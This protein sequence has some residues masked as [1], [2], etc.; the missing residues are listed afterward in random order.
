[1]IK[2]KKNIFA[3]AFLAV[4][5]LFGQSAYA[6]LVN[7]STLNFSPIANFSISS[8]LPAD[9]L[10]S[11]FAMEV[12][13]G[14]F[15]ITPLTSFNGLVLGTT[16]LASSAPVV[17]NIDNP[18]QFFGNIGASQTISDANVL[19][20]SG[21]TATVDF[22][23]WNITWNA[24]PSIDMS[25]GA[26]NGNAEGIA[27]ITCSNGSGCGNGATYILDYSA[28]VP[29]NDPSGYGIVSYALRLEGTISAV[30]LPAS[31]WLFGSGLLGLAGLVHR[32]KHMNK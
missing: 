29:Q 8:Q 24:I 26:W 13:P 19:S 11:W 5:T 28:T 21:D 30:P 15:V 3:Q 7:G 31:I 12:Q 17:A 6:A 9:G 1:M 22:D 20:T 18:W 4:A 10:G 25:T 16:Q 32:K 2:M 23:G 14:E 27:D